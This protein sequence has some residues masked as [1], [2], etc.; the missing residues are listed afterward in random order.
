ML[1]PQRQLKNYGSFSK[2]HFLGVAV[3][4][5]IIGSY[6]LLHIFAA[7]PLKGDINNDNSVNITDLSLLLSSYG[8]TTTQCITNTAYTCD[9]S[10][11]GDNL[12]NV[13]DLSIL[14]SNYGKTPSSGTGF[15]SA[16]GTQLMLNSQPYK[17]TGLNYYQANSRSGIYR[18]CGY[19][20]NLDRDLTDWG[21]GKEVMRAWFFQSFATADNGARDWS[22]FD[23]T[24]ATA[25]AHGYKVIMVLAD[26]WDSCENAPYRTRSWYSSGYKTTPQSPGMSQ[27]Y[28]DYVQSIVTRYK[29]NDTVLM[30]QLINEAEDAN[31]E[32]GACALDAAQVLRS[33]ADDMGAVIKGIDS[34][35]LVSL[36]TMGGGQCGTEDTDYPLVYQS[37]VIDVCEY[38]DYGSLAPIPGD[39]WNGLQARINQ[40]KALNKPLFTGEAGILIRDA[41]SIQ[42]RSDY[43]A[44]KV[45]AQLQAGLVGF[46]AWGYNDAAHGGSMDDYGIGPGDPLLNILG[47][48]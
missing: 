2:L 39:Q 37:P 47:A 11:P 30:W 46:L 29:D 1:M 8:Q 28:R 31:T 15:V 9:L 25:K 35:H 27:T 24:L 38:H 16:Q 14:L 21:S 34:N 36:G 4:F 23:Q 42:A 32:G 10:A 41:G 19:T 33:F 13:F 48:Y 26:Q 3:T 22:V 17:F 45:S 6:I 20:P 43:F 5:G 12:V 7:S 40:C 18:A 44:G